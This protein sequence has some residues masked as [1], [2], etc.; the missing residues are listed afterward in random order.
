MLSDKPD[1]G[2]EG[3]RRSEALRPSADGTRPECRNCWCEF[4]ALLLSQGPHSCRS[5]NPVTSHRT[6]QNLERGDYW[7]E[8]VPAEP[9]RPVADIGA[10]LEQRI[11]D[12]PRW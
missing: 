6:L 4:S 2:R 3:C 9:R 5:R 11:F 7:I 12:L 10:L 8:P 1:P